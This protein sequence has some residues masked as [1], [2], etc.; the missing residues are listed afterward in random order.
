MS[1][2]IGMTGFPDTPPNL[3]PVPLADE[4]AGVFGAMAGMMAIYRR[5]ADRRITGCPAPGRWLTSACSSRCS[6]SASRT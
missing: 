6:A 2:Y 4:I 3:P 5:D 1:G